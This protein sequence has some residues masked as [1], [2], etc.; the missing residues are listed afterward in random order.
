MSEDTEVNYPLLLG[1]YFWSS[2]ANSSASIALTF[3]RYVVINSNIL[4]TLS[5]LIN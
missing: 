1:T 2:S 4:S 3:N 5:I